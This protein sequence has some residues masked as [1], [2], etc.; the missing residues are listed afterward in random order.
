M[1][2]GQKVPERPEDDA[3]PLW[4]IRNDASARRLVR[5]KGSLRT[6]IGYDTLLSGKVESVELVDMVEAEVVAPYAPP[7][8]QLALI[9]MGM[10]L[11]MILGSQFTPPT[12]L[13]LAM[14]AVTFGMVAGVVGLT[15]SPGQR[16]MRITTRS[17]ATYMVSYRTEDEDRVR[18]LLGNAVWVDGNITDDQA[19]LRPDEERQAERMRVA[20]ALIASAFAMAMLVYALDTDSDVSDAV[21]TGVNIFYLAVLALTLIVAVVAWYKMTRLGMRK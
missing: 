14:V 11:G 6:V 7:R 8:P 1:H 19:A 16:L 13:I 15:T 9:I 17:G 18:R 5:S 20:T 12:A 21:A 4:L 3:P 10:S 2:A